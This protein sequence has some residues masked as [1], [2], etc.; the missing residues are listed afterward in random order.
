MVQELTAK[1][2][3]DIKHQAAPA[4]AVLADIGKLVQV[5]AVYMEILVTQLVTFLL[6]TA[7]LVS[8]VKDIQAEVVHTDTAGDSLTH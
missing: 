2:G 8:W 1:H 6:T 7:A 4:E 3:Q 5:M